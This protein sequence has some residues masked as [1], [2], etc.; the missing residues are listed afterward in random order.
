MDSFHCIEKLGGIGMSSWSETLVQNG[1]NGFWTVQKHLN[2][3]L[4]FRSSSCLASNP[5]LNHGLVPNSSGSNH[6]SKPD[7]SITRCAKA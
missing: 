1:L 5:D 2:V 3:G 7:L 4:D 6:G